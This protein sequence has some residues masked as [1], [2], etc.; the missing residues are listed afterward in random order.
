MLLTPI[1]AKT[2]LELCHDDRW[3]LQEKFDGDG[4]A[5]TLDLVWR[6]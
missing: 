2:L 1:G 5:V 3:V 4:D 6:P